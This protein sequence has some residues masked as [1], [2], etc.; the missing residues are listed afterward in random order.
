MDFPG[1]SCQKAGISSGT[2]AS[3]SCVKLDRMST[4]IVIEICNFYK[5][6]I[7]TFAEFCNT[8]KLFNDGYQSLNKST[9]SNRVNSVL[10]QKKNLVSKYKN[11]PV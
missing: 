4:G 2:I 9:L 10:D 3:K 11:M 6:N 8:L 1:P 5:K 7:Q